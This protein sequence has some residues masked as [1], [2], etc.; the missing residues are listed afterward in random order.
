MNGEKYKRMTVES[1]VDSFEDGA[2]QIY[3][4]ISGDM[5]HRV[6]QYCFKNSKFKALPMAFSS[7]DEGFPTGLNLKEQIALYQLN[8][9]T[10]EE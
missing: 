6:I 8:R 5:A 1:I 7:L 4:R 9:G 2:D 3:N 10:F